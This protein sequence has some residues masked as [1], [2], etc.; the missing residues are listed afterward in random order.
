MRT[1]YSLMHLKDRSPSPASREFMKILRS[2][3][4]EQKALEAASDRKR[5]PTT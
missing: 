2:V 4:A 5:G 1:S 3:E